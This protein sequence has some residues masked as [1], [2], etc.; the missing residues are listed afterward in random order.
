MSNELKWN[1]GFAKFRL[2]TDDCE[3]L[4]QRTSAKCRSFVGS[5]GKVL[6]FD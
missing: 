2:C 5:R 1:R 3:I 6:L 4:F